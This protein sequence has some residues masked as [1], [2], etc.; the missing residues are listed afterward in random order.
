MAAQYLEQRQAAEFDPDDSRS[1]EL[2]YGAKLLQPVN[3]YA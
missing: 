2:K 1:L 3:P